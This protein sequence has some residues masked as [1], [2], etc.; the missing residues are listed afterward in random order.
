MYIQYNIEEGR[1]M[2]LAVMQLI[3]NKE[4]TLELKGKPAQVKLE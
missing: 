2:I 3:Q 1:W 4:R